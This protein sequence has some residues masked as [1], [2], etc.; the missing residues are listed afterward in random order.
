MVYVDT[1][2]PFWSAELAGGK[3]AGT[4]LLLGAGAAAATWA[5]SGHPA[6]RAAALTAWAI[7]L[8]LSGWEHW[9]LRAALGSDSSPWHRSA[10]VMIRLQKK[11]N[12]ARL[13]LLFLTG[14]VL[15]L[16]ALVSPE[17]APPLLAP[18]LL[19]TVASQ[20]I[21]RHQ[22]FTAAAGP[23]MPGCRPT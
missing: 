14:A 2:R 7:R 6:A 16:S 8:I 1:R 5:W 12:R 19:C 23:T 15:P 11:R 4:A 17:S 3:F 22:F 18:A 9:K 20:F 13:V 10:L 21:E